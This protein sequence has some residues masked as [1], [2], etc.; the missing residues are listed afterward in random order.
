MKIKILFIFLML[1]CFNFINGA[2]I[3]STGTG[4]WA[5]TSSWIGGVVPTVNDDVIIATGSVITINTNVSAKSLTINGK[6]LVSGDRTVTTSAGNTFNVVINGIL[7]FATNQST[8]RFS[9]GTILDINAPGKIDDSGG[10]SNNVAIFIGAVKFAVCA[11]GGNAEYTFDELNNLGG[12]VQSKPASNA[13]ICEGS[14]LTF[15]AAKDGADGASLNWIWSIKSPGA[16]VFTQYPSKQSVVSFTSAASGS[17]EATLTYTTTYGGTSYTSAQTIFATVNSKPGIPT[18][19]ASGPIAFCTG[20]SV[21]LSSSTGTTYLWSTGAIT[22]SINVTTAGNYSVQV[23]NATNCQSLASDITT[24]TIK[25]V[26]T[27]PNIDAIVQPT[28]V[29]STGSISLSGLPVTKAAMPNWYIQQSGAVSRTY[30]GGDAPNSTTY[31][32]S[33]LDVGFYNFVIEYGDNCPVSLNNIE[34]KA[35]ITNVWKGTTLGWSKGSTPINTDSIE[36]AEDYQSTGNLSGCSCKVDSGKKVTINSGHTLTIDNSVNVSTNTGTSLTFENN[37]SLVQTANVIN[38]GDIIYKRISSPM[39]ALDYTYWSSPVLGQKLNLLSPNSDPTKFYYYNNGWK[40]EGASNPMIVGKGY[41]IRVPKAGTWPG[42]T[43]S[44]PY[45]QPVAFKG[46]PNNG[47]IQGETITAGNFYLVGNPYPSAIDADKFILDVTNNAITKGTLYFWTHNTA[48]ANNGLGYNV[49][50]SDDYASYNITGSTVTKT[51]ASSPGNNTLPTG[52]IAAGQSFM[53]E[54]RGAGTIVFNNGMRVVGENNQ[55]FRP[56]KTSKTTTIEKNRVWLNLINDKGAFKQILV[57]YIEGATNG[58][59][60]NF[61]GAA[62]NANSY[63][64]FYSINDKINYSIQGRALPFTDTDVV[65]L[66]YSSTTAGDFTIEIDKVDGSLSNQVV[67]LEDKTLGTIYNLTQNGYKFTTAIGTF[68][69]RFVLRYTN[70]T[71]GTGDFETVEN[72]ILV[73]VANKEITVNAIS[74]AIDKVFIYDVSGKLI[75]KKDKIENSKFVIENLKSGNQL[76]L[77]KVVLDNK[78]VETKKV[79]F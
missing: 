21:T 76:L 36:F 72:V 47:D 43:V 37:A 13:P 64:D 55:F 53:L 59:D 34:I 11:G 39:K 67:Y 29:T 42:E 56:S 30:I 41:I 28:C 44:Y 10:C 25:S 40:A 58:E 22:Q 8:I 16:T 69:N 66:G 75:Y 48:I 79:I 63:I 71:L 78:H 50:S 14:T 38:T 62:F 3:T 6:L 20:G 15:T 33:N 1:F 5:S 35:P 57:G 7:G 18:I 74:Q 24:V 51:A 12:T 4:N 17:Y 52:K 26:L 46:V 77:I 45:S 2:T 19:T 68:D 61:D 32:I 65:P 23:A 54:S 9:A 60:N 27:Q 70:K 73:S 49:Y 31:T